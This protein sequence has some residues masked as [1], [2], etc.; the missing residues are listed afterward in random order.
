MQGRIAHPPAYPQMKFQGI[1]NPS[2]AVLKI[3]LPYLRSAKISGAF[4]AV[5]RKTGP[6]AFIFALLLKAPNIFKTIS[7]FNFDKAPALCQH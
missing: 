5:L 7:Q 6:S 2:E 3:R 4:F 1:I